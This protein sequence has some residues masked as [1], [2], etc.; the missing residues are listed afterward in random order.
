VEGRINQPPRQISVVIGVVDRAISPFFDPVS[1]ITN[2]HQR[3]PNGGSAYDDFRN[4]GSAYDDFRNG[5]DLGWHYKSTLQ[6]LAPVTSVSRL[7]DR[8]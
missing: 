1:S 4:G 2:H 8:C 6:L 3:Q 5:G 7:R